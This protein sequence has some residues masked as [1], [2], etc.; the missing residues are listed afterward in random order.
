MSRTADHGFDTAVVDRE[1]H[2]IALV[3]VKAH[4]EERWAR[5]EPGTG[6]D[7]CLR[8]LSRSVLSLERV[9]SERVVSAHF[10]MRV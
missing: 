3:E 2:T 4:P 9:V 7:A 10:L 5:P 8:S 1:D 6:S